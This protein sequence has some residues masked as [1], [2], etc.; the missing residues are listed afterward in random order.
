MKTDDRPVKQT[1]SGKGT[2]PR[3]EA[4]SASSKPDQFF[5]KELAG[6]TPPSYS[7]MERLYRL[8]VKLY[9]LSPWDVLNETELVLARDSA[10]GETC[11]CSVMGALGEVLAVHAY[12]GT[13]GY[14]LFRTLTAGEIFGAGE[15]YERQHS[16]YVDFVP[17]AELDGQDRKLLAAMGHPVRGFPA[18]PVFRASR[19][20][21][22]PWYVT[23][24]EGLLLAECLRA[25]IV[26]CSAVSL[27][28]DLKYW[29][30][31]DTYPMLSQVDGKEGEPQYRVELVKA[32][33]PSEPPLSPVQLGEEQLHRLRNRDY[34]I[35]GVME[36]DYFPSATPIGEKHERKACTRLALA[37]D[38]DSGF[39][40]SPEIA[41]PGVSVADALGM[42]IIKA[43]EASRTL[44]RE[45]RVTTRKFKDCLNPLSEAYGFPVRVV[46]SLPALAEAREG[47]MRMMEGAAF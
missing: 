23:E 35:R 4:N 29:N 20:G 2:M 7:T 13:E 38:A 46:G 45:V 3:R 25:V 31:V 36:L 40:F 21:F 22:R 33:L 47:L 15:F 32:T 1:G 27:R 9:T 17:R 8:A 43:I 10:T 24:Q 39:L 41:A 34:A 42:V 28:S 26:I 16:V 44:P 12:I 11:Y 6:E 5:A 14:R 30:R 18:S 37:V 19:P